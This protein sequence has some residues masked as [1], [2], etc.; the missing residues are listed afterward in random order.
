VTTATRSATRTAARTAALVGIA[1]AA[2]WSLASCAPQPAAEGTDV[3]YADGS[4]TA[5][6]DYV[7]P[8]GP[9]SI[10]VDLTL[11]GD[12][13]TAVTVTP[14]A[15]GG[16]REAGFQKQF[17][18]NIADEVVGTDIDELEVSR[19]AGSSLTSTG[20]NAAIDDIKQQAA[21]SG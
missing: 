21:A 6:G 5:D 13:V 11:E 12:T 3:A 14:H 7:A 2:A 1:G 8:S 20:F 15:E 16:T 4:Y 19:V 18:D 17:A 10:T 9:E